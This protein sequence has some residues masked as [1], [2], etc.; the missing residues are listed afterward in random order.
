[1]KEIKLTIYDHNIWGN[2]PS[3]SKISNRNAAVAELVELYSA[4]IVSFQECNPKT[5]REPSVDIAKMLCDEYNEACPDMAGVNFTPLFYKKNRFSVIEEGF[6]SYEGKNDQNSKS[7]TYAVL[8]ERES[9]VRF[10]AICTHFWWEAKSEADNLQRIENARVLLSYVDMIKNKYDVPVF[11]MGDLN[12]GKFSD[13][14]EEPY[15]YLCERLLDVRETAPVSTD[16]L[17]HHEYPIRD[18]KD[19]YHVPLDKTPYR[20]LDHSFVTEHKCVALD[21]FA[22]DTSDMAYISSDH[23][24]LIAEV[25]VFGE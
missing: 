5:S 21:S 10:G 12:C 11:A 19:I 14:G 4:D 2:M 17:T 3:T 1:M 25:R 7:L 18:E 23:F 15:L 13:Q 20:T 16:T 22:V 6:V 24:P 8:E 9:G